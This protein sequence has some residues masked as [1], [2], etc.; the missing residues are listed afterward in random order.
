MQP[1]SS[2]AYETPPPLGGAGG[3]RMGRRCLV[4]T[5]LLT[6]AAPTARANYVITDLGVIPGGSTS[7]G[8]ALNASGLVTGFGDPGTLASHAIVVS[9]GAGSATDL[10]T[11]GGQSSHG[12]GIN[13]SGMVVGDSDVT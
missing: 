10:G 13:S 9:A 5:V 1:C 2:M 6:L 7:H 3:N 4:A 12:A 11:L 8:V